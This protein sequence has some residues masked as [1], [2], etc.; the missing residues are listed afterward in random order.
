MQIELRDEFRHRIGQIDVDPVQRPTRVI[1]ADESRSWIL[2][3]GYWIQKKWRH[4]LPRPMHPHGPIQNSK[5]K[6]QNQPVD[7][8]SP[9]SREAFLNWET[10]LD[11][12]GQLRRCVACGC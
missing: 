1:V 9:T 3:F 5:S 10:A 11:D 7:H 12:A 4:L 2:D 6:I 8:P